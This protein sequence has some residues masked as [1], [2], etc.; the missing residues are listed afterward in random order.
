M[1]ALVYSDLQATESSV[2]CFCDPLCNL[3]RWRVNRFYKKLH[4]IYR[5]HGCS[6]LWDLGDTTDDRTAVSIPTL[7][8]VLSSLASFPGPKDNIKLIGNHEQWI[9]NAQIHTGHIYEAFF[10]VVCAE[11]VCVHKTGNTHVVCCPFP[12][13]ENE[14][15]KE[16]KA[17][18]GDRST[19]L[20]GHF[21]VK[22]CSMNSG[23]AL[24]GVPKDLLSKFGLVLLGHIHKPQSLSTR[25]HYVG[26][27][28][29]QNFGEANEN[30]RVGIVDTDSLEVVWVPID[31]MPQYAEV[32]LDA[33]K[34]MVNENS[35]DRF[36]VI[37]STPEE[38]AEFYAHPLS[39]RGEAIIAYIHAE[40]S[41]PQSERSERTTKAILED[42]VKEH[43]VPIPDYPEA[44][45]V[46]VGWSIVENAGGGSSA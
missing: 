6:A 15:I 7:Q 17:I 32:D 8:A 27:P 45:C 11:S 43:K 39:P 42:W 26:S 22:G 36:K 24:S 40:E 16:L 21:Q 34:R 37:L 25:I 38:A 1:K 19:I 4:R 14:F 2:N 20:L 33:F 3:Q 12:A 29:Q 18:E 31:N 13:D 5:E 10:E 35:E 28:F 9:K 30:K 46:S 41:V 23:P 44:E